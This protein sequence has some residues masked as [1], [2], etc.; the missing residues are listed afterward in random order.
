MYRFSSEISAWG[1]FLKTYISRL[2]K[3]ETRNKK[4]A[5]V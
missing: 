5:Y 2:K 4:F 1:D 3:G